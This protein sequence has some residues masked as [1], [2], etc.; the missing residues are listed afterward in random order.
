MTA[1]Q[2]GGAP[3]IFH[4]TYHLRPPFYFKVAYK[5]FKPLVPERIIRNVRIHAG[6][7][8]GGFPELLEEF[9][10]TVLPAELGGTMTETD[11]GDQVNLALMQNEGYFEDV[12][13]SMKKRSM[14]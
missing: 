1:F 5:M 14:S 7:G 13:N 12:R 9:C 10:E 3:V 4:D 6:D 8:E 2:Q 11:S